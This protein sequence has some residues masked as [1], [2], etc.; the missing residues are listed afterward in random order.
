MPA[1]GEPEASFILNLSAPQRARC[2]RERLWLVF[3]VALL[4]LWASQAALA[5]TGREQAKSAAGTWSHAYAAY[6]I[7]K[8]PRGFA[9]FDYVNPDAPKG[10]TLQLSQPDRR[11]SFDKYNPFTVKGQSPAGLTTLMFES[12][13]VRSADEPAT[14]Y[15]LLAEDMKVAPDKSSITFRLHPKARFANGE[16]VTT[17]DVRHAFDMLTSK[18]AAPGVRTQFDGVQGVAVLDPRA[19]RFDLKDRTDDTIFNVGGLPVFSVKWGQGSDGKP[20]A[21]DQI[22]TEYPITSGPYTV[23]LADSGRRIDFA[24]NPD[25]W[26]RDLG[27]SRGQYNFDRVVYRYYQDN[28]VSLEAFKAGEFDLLLEYSARRWARQ[29]GG[30]KWNDGRIIKESFPNGFGAGLQAY[31]LNLRRPLF[32]D[33]RVRRAINLAY[34]FE[35]VNVYRQYKR[36]NSLFANSDFAAAGL[37]GAGELAL[38]EKFRGEL[39]AEV[40]GAAWEPPRTDTGPNALRENLKRARTLLEQ[41]GWKVAADGVLRNGK[42]EPLEFELLEAGEAPGRA[43]AVFQR[44]FEKLGITLKLRLVDFALYRKRLETFDFDM[45]IIRVGDF[46]LPGAADLKSMYGSQSA[47]VEG[48]N[49]YRGLKSAAVD[50]LIASMEKA[51]TMEALRDAA[52]ALDRVIMHGYYQ[53]PDLYLGANRVSRWDRLG[54]P[55]TVPKYYTIAS[56]SEWLQWAVTAWWAKD[57]A[58]R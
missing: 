43:E 32:Q 19:I 12:L 15:G 10:G 48:S 6:G 36:T 54:I 49:N 41:A 39:P 21:F 52:R 46:T 58:Q 29:H 1:C 31:V 9:H 45:T 3:S 37:P 55:G 40:F 13:A 2:T 35:A 7:P 44:N 23:A 17:A 27:V 28:A 5:S 42:G 25:Y 53:V 51:R 4:S 24:R 50:H 34:D 56:P 47:D 22:V 57:A 11:T 30:P 14:M 16:P 33:I 26:A 18:A 20:R 38:L 8:Y